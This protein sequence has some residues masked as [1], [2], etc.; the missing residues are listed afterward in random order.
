ML[1]LKTV[2]PTR[3]SGLCWAAQALLSNFLVEA[4]DYMDTP[5]VCGTSLLRGQ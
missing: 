2:I 5:L 3:V 4:L 1:A